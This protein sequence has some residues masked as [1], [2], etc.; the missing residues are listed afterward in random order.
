AA[1][2]CSS[3]QYAIAAGFLSI[4]AL[5]S[6]RASSYPSS[7]RVTTRPRTAPSRPDTVDVA[8]SAH[9]LWCG[10]ADHN[11]RKPEKL[12]VEAGRVAGVVLERPREHPARNDAVPALALVRPEGV[13]ALVLVDDRV[14]DR[15]RLG[16]A[17]DDHDLVTLE[18]H[19]DVR[20]ARDRA[21]LAR[22][23]AA[24]EDDRLVPPE[25][26][27]RR[28]VRSRRC[29]PVVAP[30]REPLGRPAPRQHPVVALRHAVPAAERGTRGRRH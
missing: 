15:D 23:R 21:C 5:K 22:A 14:V 7:S 13:L 9:P 27:H 25:R 24:A 30:L 1:T 2:S 3:T 4:I 16:A 10:Q 26:P 11:A 20:V 17:L 28:G 19:D 29:H 12:E 8:I 18:V 6:E